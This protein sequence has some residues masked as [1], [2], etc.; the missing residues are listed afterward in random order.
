MDILKA[1]VLGI[2]EGLTEFL[3]I[4]STGHMILVGRW[5]AFPAS[6]EKTFE[7]FIQIGAVGAVVVYY[8]RRLAGWLSRLWREPGLANPGV[9]VLVAFLPAAL[10]GF[11]THR[12]IEAHLFSPRVVAAA[13][14]A[15]GVMLW[16][17]EA[18]APRG[19]IVSADGVGLGRALAIGS[20]QCLA[21]VPGVSR[22]AATIVGGLLVGL[23]PVAAVEFSFLLSIPT[24]AAASGYSLLKAYHLLSPDDVLLLLVGLVTA[25][26]VALAVVAFFIS[27]VGRHRMTPLAI[28]RIILGLIV[29]AA[30]D[31]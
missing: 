13:L 16:A 20:F 31:H 1:L 10:L 11:L 29:L 4:S 9:A 7:V 30:V 8:R 18:A 6:L 2:V 21:L 24:L 23:T 19:T 17:V 3:P 27:W 22:S 15:G 28:Y 5:I 26:L 12:W 14:V 25:Y